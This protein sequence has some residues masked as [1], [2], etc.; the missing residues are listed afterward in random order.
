MSDQIVWELHDKGYRALVKFIKVG[1]EHVPRPCSASMSVH[2][3][4]KLCTSSPEALIFDLTVTPIR[5]GWQWQCEYP[6]RMMWGKRLTLA[7]AQRAAAEALVAA[8]EDMREEHQA[9]AERHQAL[10]DSYRDAHAEAMRW[11]EKPAPERTRSAA[12]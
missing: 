2:C 4:P 1:D 9:L 5:G 3:S 12:G 8:A 10:A 7:A 6:H 11:I